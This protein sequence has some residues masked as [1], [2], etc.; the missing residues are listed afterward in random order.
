ME[1]RQNPDDPPRQEPGVTLELASVGE[2][3]GAQLVDDPITAET[4]SHRSIRE[5]DEAFASGR[6]RPMRR[7]EPSADT[8]AIAASGPPRASPA[9]APTAMNTSRTARRW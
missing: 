5:L 7:D 9:G 4:P 1:D 8:R 2:V 3:R 6:R